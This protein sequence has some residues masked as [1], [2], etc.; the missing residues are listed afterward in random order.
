MNANPTGPLAGIKVIE[1]AHVMAGPT[2]GRMLADMGAE[3]IKVEK[4][5]GGDEVRYDSMPNEPDDKTSHAFMMLNRNKKSIVINLKTSEGKE[6]L[7]DLL[8]DADVVIENYRSDTMDKLGF[9]W[10]RI[11]KD[12]PRIV[13]CAISG[14][15]RTGPYAS[16]GGF[17]LIAQGMS[18]LMSIT[19]EE[20][21]EAPVKVGP[22]VTDIT[23]GV[24]AAMGVVAA[25]FARQSTGKGQFVETS[26]LEAG[27][28]FTYWHSAMAFATGTCPGP[29]GSAHPLGAPYQAYQT[30]DGWIT[31]GG[32]SEANWRRL[33]ALTG[34]ETI[35][36]DPRFKTNSVRNANRE[37]LNEILA[38]VF[39]S[40]TTAEWM[41]RLE[42][43]GVP[44][45]PIL[46]VPEML[47]D[48]QVAAR[49]MVPVLQHPR[50]GDVPTIG[51]PVKFSETPAGIRSPAP[52]LGQHTREIMKD[53]GYSDDKI[54][55]LIK[56]KSVIG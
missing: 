1:L 4:A 20:G 44:A 32:A 50:R 29:L 9:G 26:L 16:K 3:V 34:H 24:L 56:S 41:E 21:G 33:A 47:K 15:G 42:Q 25:L 23:S 22:P 6:L 49:D 52:D 14:F 54:D 18:G 12:F 5:P 13:Y 2:C 35:A 7:E 38:P 10:S 51:F 53:L 46:S 40:R 17:D 39:K 30:S 11:E 36:D 48:P 37:A 31:I 27:V 43:E 55:D 28:I 19:G 45:G 8:K